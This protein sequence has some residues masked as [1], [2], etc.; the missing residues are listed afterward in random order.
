MKRLVL[1]H[2]GE[3]I[4]RKFK[5]LQLLKAAPRLKPNTKVIEEMSLD[6]DMNT[7]LVI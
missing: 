2:N 6:P 1:S 3:A 5:E 4:V 7:V